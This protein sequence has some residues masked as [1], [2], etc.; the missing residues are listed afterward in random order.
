MQSP[1]WDRLRTQKLQESGYRCLDCGGS[2]RLEVH[3]LT[4]ERFGHERLTDLQVL[5]HVCHAEAHGRVPSVG[6]IAGP[7]V[8]DMTADIKARED[9][10]RKQ[11]EMLEIAAL[12][13]SWD[14][15]TPALEAMASVRAR[16][17]LRLIDREMDKLAAEIASP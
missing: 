14:D 10:E 13:R 2:E 8:A 12:R 16:K 3:H 15:L 17:R 7:T 1:E 9:L 6:P 4:Y 11:A 5:C